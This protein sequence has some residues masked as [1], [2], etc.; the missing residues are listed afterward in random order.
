[1]NQHE[2]AIVAL[3]A[4]QAATLF[5]LW[6][7]HVDREWFRMAWLRQGRELLNIKKDNHT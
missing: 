6:R 3:L 7:T 5:L 2:I 4:L 1:M